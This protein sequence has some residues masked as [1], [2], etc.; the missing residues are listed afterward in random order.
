MSV[1][2]RIRKILGETEAVEVVEV[3]VLSTGPKDELG[4]F[5]PSDP[6]PTADTS[7]HIP[8]LENLTPEQGF[9]FAPDAAGLSD[10]VLGVA[11]CPVCGTKGSSG[12]PCEVDGSVIP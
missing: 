2:K 8:L 10:T 11:T 3:E 12:K 6:N 4:D 7:K 1:K 5:L 9:S